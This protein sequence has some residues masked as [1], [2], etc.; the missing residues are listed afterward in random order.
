MGTMMGMVMPM[1]LR[2]KIKRVKV[3]LRMITMKQRLQHL[4]IL[5]LKLVTCWRGRPAWLGP[6]CSRERLS[7]D[8]PKA[9]TLMQ[10]TLARK[11]TV[12]PRRTGCCHLTGQP[13]SV[14]CRS[15]SRW[16]GDSESRRDSSRNPLLNLLMWTEQGSRNHFEV[17][18]HL[19]Q[20]SHFWLE[21]QL[22]PH[23]SGTAWHW[24][25]IERTDIS[26]D[27]HRF[28]QSQGLVG[29]Q[30]Y[31]WPAKLL[32]DNNFNIVI[33]SLPPPAEITMRRGRPDISIRTKPTNC[34]RSA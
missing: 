34:S 30:I 5:L 22:C 13:W 29:N 1:V 14:Q 10:G 32:G 2:K 20:R 12:L 31:S 23:C 21:D 17:P 28:W 16:D 15:Q 7:A 11:L 33:F 3:R 6:S 18:S 8:W 26:H 24:P 27:W 4:Q 9:S 25:A 19:L